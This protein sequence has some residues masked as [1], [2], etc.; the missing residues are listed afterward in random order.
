MKK[1]F[2][3]LIKSILFDAQGSENTKDYLEIYMNPT[4]EEINIVKNADQ[5]KSIRGIIDN[6][7]IYIWIG[8]V[9]HDQLKNPK[10]NI[11]NSLHFTYEKNRWKIDTCNLKI[12]FKEIYDILNNYKNQLSQIGNLDGK[13]FIGNTIDKIGSGD[14]KGFF[15][16]LN[17]EKI[18]EF[19]KKFK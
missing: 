12:T 8:N 4:Q 13:I 18:D 19:Y 2:K 3:R 11:S 14:I 6:G 1:I 17:W 10:I 16:F 7:N 15:D 9:I 5:F